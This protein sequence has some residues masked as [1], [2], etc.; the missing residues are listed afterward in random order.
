MVQDQHD[1]GRV[2]EPTRRMREGSGCLQRCKVFVG[3]YAACG[4]WAARGVG[5]SEPEKGEYDE[6]AWVSTTLGAFVVYAFF[7]TT[8][9]NG[10]F[11]NNNDRD[12]DDAACV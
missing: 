7:V 3:R 8:T 11:V 6:R 1:S 9:C 5:G 2:A 12:D 10:D 4:V